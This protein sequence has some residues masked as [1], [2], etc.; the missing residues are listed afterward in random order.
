M[1]YNDGSQILDEGEKYTH[2]LT[3][4]KGIAGPRKIILGKGWS[5]SSEE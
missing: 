3:F 2:F 4:L 5:D 1:M